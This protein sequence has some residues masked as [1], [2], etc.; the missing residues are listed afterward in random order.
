MTCEGSLLLT[1]D[2]IGL[3][4]R[5]GLGRNDKMCG[6]NHT[7]QG[8]YFFDEKFFCNCFRSHENIQIVIVTRFPIF[9][10]K[11]KSIHREFLLII[12]NNF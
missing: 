6:L 7:Y 10:Q 3:G 1:L 2:E 8:H 11:K 5:L 12:A 4:L 9:L